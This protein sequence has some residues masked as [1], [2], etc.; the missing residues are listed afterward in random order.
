MDHLR[1]DAEAWTR[2]EG[3]NTISWAVVIG[4]LSALICLVWLRRV[5]RRARIDALGPGALVW[6]RPPDRKQ[7]L[8]R[9]LSRGPSHF[10]IE[11]A[12]GDARWWVPAAPVE[13]ARGGSLVEATWLRE[14]RQNP[15][16]APER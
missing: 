5:A 2:G 7:L 10:W 13:R 6:V 4:A 16:R 9:V 8:A 1:L 15:P 11:L 3:M 14:A 12:P